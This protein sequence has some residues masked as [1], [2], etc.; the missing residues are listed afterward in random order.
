[1]RHI[2]YCMQVCLVFVTITFTSVDVIEKEQRNYAELL[3][4]TSQIEN[5][6]K[7]LNAVQYTVLINDSGF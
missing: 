2:G 4:L 7:W 5:K 3:S 1:M 6:K